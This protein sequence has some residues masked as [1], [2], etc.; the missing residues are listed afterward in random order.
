MIGPKEGIVAK[1]LPKFEDWTPPWGEDDGK[2]D[3]ETAKKLIYNLT[4]E[5]NDR[6][7]TI[8]SLRAEKRQ[9]EKDRDE[10][11]AENM[12]AEQRAAKAVED[13][14]AEGGNELKLENARLRIALEKGLT[15]TQLRY[16]QGKDESELEAN[17]D[18]LLQDFPAAGGGDGGKGDE[19]KTKDRPNQRRT[20]VED[21]RTGAGKAGSDDVV[22]AGTPEDAFKLLEGA[23]SDWQ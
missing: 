22:L 5:R 10:A 20:P 12:T 17:A 8:S 7:G 4:S 13:A 16:F 2:L 15:P 3:A 21:L 23:D 1:D 6:D 14:K 18:Q 19:G 11:K 9:A